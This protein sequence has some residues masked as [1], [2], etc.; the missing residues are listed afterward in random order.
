MALI[1]NR[2]KYQF[3]NNTNKQEQ[4][5]MVTKQQLDAMGKILPMQMMEVCGVETPC[6]LLEDVI[7]VFKLNK[8]IANNL[9]EN[10][11]LQTVDYIVSDDG[12]LWITA[13]ALLHFADRRQRW[14]TRKEL[15]T[16]YLQSVLPATQ[17][18]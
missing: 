6:A 3:T 1:L 15:I 12:V 7:A 9:V 11:M 16:A 10:S 4:T 17:E 18:G 8:S 5:G 13:E 14:L 2:L